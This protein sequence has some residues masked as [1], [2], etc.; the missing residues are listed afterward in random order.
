[1]E[2]ELDNGVAADSD[3]VND[4]ESILLFLSLPCNCSIQPRLRASLKCSVRH[5]RSGVYSSDM[6]ATWL[7]AEL[8]FV[9][10]CA[11]VCHG[12]HMCTLLFTLDGGNRGNLPLA[13]LVFSTLQV[14]VLML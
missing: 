6:Y 8:Q 10:H 12:R 7:T 2:A 3:E 9:M 13:I 1:M 14:T 4:L 11:L 5:V